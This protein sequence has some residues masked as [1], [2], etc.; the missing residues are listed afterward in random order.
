MTIKFCIFDLV[1]VPN[2]TL[3]KQFW[4]LGKKLFKDI[5]KNGGQ[6][7]SMFVQVYHVP[8]VTFTAFFR[9]ARYHYSSNVSKT[10]QR[11]LILEVFFTKERKVTFY[12]IEKTWQLHEKKETS[13]V[14]KCFVQY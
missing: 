4:I 12:R 9:I 13:A 7:Q 11:Q 10:S 8:S 14:F 2:F 3:N 6:I 1:Q 5:S